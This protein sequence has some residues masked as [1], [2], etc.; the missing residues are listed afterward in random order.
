MTNSNSK[1]GDPKFFQRARA[2]DYADN[3][4][5]NK[6]AHDA[7]NK[8]QQEKFLKA[9]SKKQKSDFSERARKGDYVDNQLFAEAARNAFDKAQV[10]VTLQRGRQRLQSLSSSFLKATSS[11]YPHLMQLRK[12]MAARRLL[13]KRQNQNSS[14]NQDPIT[15][16]FL[17][18][19]PFVLFTSV[20]LLLI[21]PTNGIVSIRLVLSSIVHA[22]VICTSVLVLAAIRNEKHPQKE[23]AS[24]KISTYRL[25]RQLFRDPIRFISLFPIWNVISVGLAI[26]ITF[27]C[28][29]SS[30]E[31]LSV[32][33]LIG[34]VT[35]LSILA[36]CFGGKDGFSGIQ[37]IYFL[38]RSAWLGLRI[39][40]ETFQIWLPR[41]LH[42][43]ETTLQE[44]INLANQYTADDRNKLP[45]GPFTKATQRTLLEWY[46]YNPF[47]SNVPA[48]PVTQTPKENVIDSSNQSTSKTDFNDLDENQTE[49]EDYFSNPIDRQIRQDESEI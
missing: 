1:S 20:I 18:V 40:A 32:A 12:L 24:N 14:P 33:L 22:L 45:I 23:T 8:E 15:S 42:G 5:F 16:L 35:L 3:Y 39:T 27:F 19:T 47:G 13:H 43:V 41:R 11:A 30:Q 37:Y 38:V 10:V 2:G 9:N 49:S 29:V 48:T 4:Q 6:S 36:I 46:E 21:S 17:G 34:F 31:K 44:Y 28:I 26:V 7:F 25:L